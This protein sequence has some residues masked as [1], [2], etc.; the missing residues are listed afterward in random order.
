MKGNLKIKQ[1]TNPLLLSTRQLE[2]TGDVKNKILE[3]RRW[4]MSLSSLQRQPTT[5][6][7]DHYQ[8]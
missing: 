7:H 1:L 5:S 3:R 4:N 6:N 8:Q 2:E